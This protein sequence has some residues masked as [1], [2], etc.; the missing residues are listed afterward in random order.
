MGAFDKAIPFAIEAHQMRLEI[1]GPGHLNTLAAHSN[2]ARAYSGAEKLMEAAE[3]Y[4][5]VL[6]IFRKEYGNDNFYISG[7]LQSYGNVYLR[8]GNYIEAEKIMRESLEHGRRLLP[9]DHIRLSY[10][11]K[12]LADA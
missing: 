2:T 8:M 1:F 5:E 4:R 3:T 10:P 9:A 12:G 6:S 7:I 11:L